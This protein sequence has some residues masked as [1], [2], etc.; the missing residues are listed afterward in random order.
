MEDLKITTLEELNDQV[1]GKKGTPKRDEFEKEIDLLRINNTKNPAAE[2]P[3]AGFS[4][5]M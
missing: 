2:T 5:L 4:M 1:F 3:T